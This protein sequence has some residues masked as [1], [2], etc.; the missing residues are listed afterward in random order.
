MPIKLAD[1]KALYESAPELATP[2]DRR[3]LAAACGLAKRA[4]V[5]N[6][7]ELL[8][9]AVAVALEG[10]S[11]EAV[12]DVKDLVEE[13]LQVTDPEF[14][15]VANPLMRSLGVLLG[16]SSLF[17]SGLDRTTRNQRMTRSFKDMLMK[18]P[19]LKDR[20]DAVAEAFQVISNYAPTLAMD[21]IASGH[22]VSNIV[23]LGQGAIS[24]AMIK[25]LIQTEQAK[26]GDPQAHIMDFAKSL[27]SMKD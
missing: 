9:K 18:N 24:P 8:D 27:M 16:G 7:Q 4:A 22:I 15:K 2:S 11:K 17:R 19:H 26:T 13:V 14:K 12:E 1:H 5:M 23:R 6:S 20:P 21:P 25:E 10:L 3:S